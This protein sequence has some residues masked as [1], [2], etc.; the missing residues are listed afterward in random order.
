MS[1]ERDGHTLQPTA[2]VHEG[3][4]R[5]LRQRKPPRTPEQWLAA[6]AVMMRRVLVD[7][8]RRKRRLK[9]GGHLARVDLPIDEVAEPEPREDLIALDEALNRYK[10]VDPEA[11][12]IVELK[13]FGGMTGAEVSRVI[14]IASRQVDRKWASAR[15]WLFCDLS[16]CADGGR[17]NG[18]QELFEEA[19]ELSA[20]LARR[21]FLDRHC[22]WN[23]VLR[24]RVERMLDD[25]DRAG[26]FL[27]EPAPEQM[28]RGGLRRTAGVAAGAKLA[29]D[30][31]MTAVKFLAAPLVAG[32]L[33]SLGSVR[34]LRRLPDTPFGPV[35]EGI[36]GPTD[37]PVLVRA[38]A[39]KHAQEPSVR[40]RFLGAARKLVMMRD[41][42]LL[43]IRRV[44]ERPVPY[45]VT[46]QT[47][48]ES[49]ADRLARGDR[50][51]VATALRLGARLAEALAVVHEQG[52]VH[53]R[54]S[55]A[56]VFVTAGREPDQAVLIDVGLAQAVDAEAD[57]LALLPGPWPDFLAPEQAGGDRLDCCDHRPDLFALG[58]LLVAMV[59][60]QSPFAA[61]TGE[62][63][64]RRVSDGAASMPESI[65]AP[66]AAVVAALHQ[67]DP[68]KRPK[69]GLAVATLLNEAA[70]KLG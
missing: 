43:S 19:V 12:Q 7:A 70:G 26:T 4:I 9:H 1:L 53:R 32:D 45:L 27:E 37:R 11:A 14:G 40:R 16:G 68:T 3:I 21:R 56:T 2:L 50:F 33:G 61:A 8:V 24:A 29:G 62:G 10:A 41:P 38:L 55:P 54:L 23:R 66:F 6:M 5:I 69:S 64:L 22:R 46:K 13:F 30:V 48:G 39:A 31:R 18:E 57:P 47:A 20:G 42:F 65:P 52:L 59:T 63:A 36:D 58:S 51:S 44:E 28:A 35:F 67:A 25:H 17:V 34:V 15:V 49:L 60:G